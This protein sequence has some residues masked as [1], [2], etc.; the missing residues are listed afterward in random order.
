MA[1]WRDNGG[2]DIHASLCLFLLLSIALFDNVNAIATKV[3]FQTSNR[4]LF[5]ALLPYGRARFT[6]WGYE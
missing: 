3:A 6:I 1:R 4:L 2:G 5:I